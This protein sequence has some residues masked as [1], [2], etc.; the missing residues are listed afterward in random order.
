MANSNVGTGMAA[1]SE[2]LVINKIETLKNTQWRDVD[3]TV[4]ENNLFLVWPLYGLL[5][6]WKT[7][8][9]RKMEIQMMEFIQYIKDY[10]RDSNKK[11]E[12]NKKKRKTIRSPSL[13]TED[14]YGN[15]NPK[16]IIY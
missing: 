1:L 6:V 3:Y 2:L 4:N 15:V 12:R 11:T 13:G 5:R 10:P 16:G 8:Q 7:A 9:N 14:L